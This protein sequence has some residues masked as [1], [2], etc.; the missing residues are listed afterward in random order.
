[1]PVCSVQSLV[2]LAARGEVQKL[3]NLIRRGVDVNQAGSDGACAL[4]AASETGRRDVV[5]LLL[6]HG[7]QNVNL[8]MDDG[9]GSLQAASQNGHCDVVELLLAA[10]GQLLIG[11]CWLLVVG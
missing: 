3:A 10:R 5:R 7:A 6:K 1:M 8:L 4:Y 9:M 11:G 2:Q